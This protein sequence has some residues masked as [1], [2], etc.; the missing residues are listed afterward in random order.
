MSP[1]LENFQKNQFW[2]FILDRYLTSVLEFHG[3]R[4][5][6]LNSE[7]KYGPPSGPKFI[8]P[9]KIFKKFNVWN[10]V[11]V[12]ARS[13]LDFYGKNIYELKFLLGTPIS[14]PVDTKFL[15]P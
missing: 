4:N 14:P 12:G 15:F 11:E 8:L 3:K 13:E 2:V 10:S 1:L 9:L 5:L 6:N 7:F